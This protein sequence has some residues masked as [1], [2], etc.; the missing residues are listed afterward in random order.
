[1]PEGKDV[2]YG[3]SSRFHKRWPTIQKGHICFRSELENITQAASQLPICSS[4]FLLLCNV[5][6]LSHLPWLADQPVRLE[7]HAEGAGVHWACQL[8]SADE[9]QNILGGIAS[10]SQFRVDDR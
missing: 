10:H 1:M 2:T 3:T 5:S 8:S 9:R 4:P 7:D 6:A